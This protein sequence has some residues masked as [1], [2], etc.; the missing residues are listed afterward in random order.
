MAQYDIAIIGGGPAGYVAAERAAAAGLRVVVF[1]ARELGGVC[2]NEGC[3]PTKT[4][5]YSA[6]TYENALNAGKYGVRAEG[7]SFDYA[8][9]VAR[10]NKVVRKLVAG[11]KAKLQGVDIVR[12]RAFIL[13]RGVN[14]FLIGGGNRLGDSVLEGGLVA[15]HRDLIGGDSFDSNSTGAELGNN[16][17]LGAVYTAANLLICTGSEAFVPPIAGVREAMEAGVLLTSREALSL[18][19]LP[20]SLVVI[21]GGVIGMEFA[22]LF[23]SLGSEVT[24]VEQMGE[25]LGGIDH[26]ISAML[27]G[28]YAKK[29]VVFHLSSRVTCVEASSSVGAMEGGAEV[30][31]MEGLSATEDT[32]NHGVESLADRAVVRFVDG[33]GIER[34]VSAEKVLISV[35][36]RPVV[37]GFGLENLGVTLSDRRGIV[38]DERM[39]TDVAGVYAAGDV[40]GGTMLA[41][42]AYRQAE[43]AVNNIVSLRNGEVRR[44]LD[45]MRYDAIPGV[46]Y[47]NPEVASVGLTLEA[48]RVKGLNVRELRLPMAYAGRFVAE[49]EGGEGV[50]KIVVIDGSVGGC[51]ADAVDRVSEGCQRVD[52][53]AVG[54]VDRVFDGGQG[55][56]S[57]AGLVS[58]GG[59][60]GDLAAGRDLDEGRYGDSDG[61]RLGGYVE[62][63]VVGVHMIGSPSSE[64]IWGAALVIE[65]GETIRDLQRIIFPHPTVSEI[66]RETAFL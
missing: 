8:K 51:G 21:G 61:D 49:N 56:D 9:I 3:I 19:E 15:R 16:D 58:S 64:M 50:C 37:D 33:E 7:V 60:R 18:K 4:L 59:H 1:E 66:I 57:A 29:G 46:V 32:D 6:K 43:V 52:L 12:D 14:G 13:E 10:K 27:R 45:A 40:T 39:Q 28:I 36:R 25:I 44:P 63:Q 26:E 41:H 5:L 38:T 62:G 11:V 53:A 34:S 22:S 24:V 2:L 42:T 35:G 47:T 20:S 17:G 31:L 55:G 48:A 54:V 30:A 23:R 65:R